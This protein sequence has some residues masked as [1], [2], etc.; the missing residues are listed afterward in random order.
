M[1]GCRPFQFLSEIDVLVAQM[2]HFV[3]DL[4]AEWR[5][6]WERLKRSSGRHWDHI[7]G[8][9]LTFRTGL[10]DLKIKTAC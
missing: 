1:F 9:F 7:P 6:E 4:P 2:I 8:T 3:E 5:T 10:T